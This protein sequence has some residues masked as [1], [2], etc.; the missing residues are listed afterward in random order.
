ME[1]W[2]FENKSLTKE[3]LDFLRSLDERL[4]KLENSRMKELTQPVKSDIPSFG[5]IPNAGI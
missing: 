3:Q 5:L 4:S 1:K 2:Y